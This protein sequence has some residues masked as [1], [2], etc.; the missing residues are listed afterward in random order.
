[1]LKYHSVI[2]KS[3][4]LEEVELKTY[5]PKRKITFTHESVFMQK[6]FRFLACP[7]SV[8]GAGQ[9]FQFSHRD[10]DIHKTL[11]TYVNENN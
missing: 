3:V 1:M 2:S 8:T 6:M 4:T 9:P 7:S 11:T 5:F 10:N